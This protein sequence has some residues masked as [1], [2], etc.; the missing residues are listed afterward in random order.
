VFDNVRVELGK[1]GD[2]PGG[3]YDDRPNGMMTNGQFGGMYTNAIAGIFARDVNGL[4]LR[5]TQ[6]V[7]LAPKNAIYGE[8]LD[9]EAIQ[10]LTLDHDTFSSLPPAK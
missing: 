7:W 5:S 8:A 10:D 6:V 9:Q 4:T 3:F 2:E 1:T